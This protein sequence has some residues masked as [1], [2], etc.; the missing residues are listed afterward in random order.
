MSNT[1]FTGAASNP[2]S[3]SLKN[4]SSEYNGIQNIR[5]W[6]NFIAKRRGIQNSAIID[7]GIM[8][9]FDLYNDGNPL[10]PNKIMVVTANGDFILF[11]YNELVIFFDYLFSPGIKLVLQS[12]DGNWWSVAP[13]EDG[14]LTTTVVSTPSNILTEDLII[15]NNQ[16]FGFQMSLSIYRL[17]VTTSGELQITSFATTGGTVVYNQNQPFQNGV[18]PIFEDAAFAHW[19][20][21][22]GNDGSLTATTVIA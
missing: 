2:D 21:E 1:V 12:P 22:I 5:G 18:G 15:E 14:I 19:R 11:D 8:G 4:T 6:G 3:G 20:L 9:M 10:S 13:D 17:N 16:F 7:S